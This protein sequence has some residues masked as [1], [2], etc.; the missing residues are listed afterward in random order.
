LRRLELRS[1]TE[2]L[3]KT[4]P[5][6]PKII[7][8]TLNIDSARHLTVKDM[9]LELNTELEEING[10]GPSIASKLKQAG[11]TTIEAVAVVPARELA[12]R[13]GLG[14]ETAEKVGIKAREIINAGFLTAGELLEKRKTMMKCPTGAKEL[15]RLLGGGIETQAITEFA[16]EFGTG[17]TQICLTLSV[18]SQLPPEKGGFGGRVLY[19][20]TE[21]TF[22]PER[23]YQIA[24]SRGFDVKNAME[25]IKI[26]K[27][28]NSDHLC[29]I[30]DSLFKVC[31]EEGVK[32][33][34]VDSIISH[35]RGE[36]LGRE[37]LPERQQKLNLYLHKLIRLA[38][39]YNLAV[40]VTNQVHAKPDAFFSDPTNP[41][42]GHV[43]AHACTQRLLLKRSKGNIRTAA[44]IDSPY[45]PAGQ[46]SFMISE[47]G[48]EDNPSAP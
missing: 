16:G 40:I 21:G 48:I 3:S 7:L 17:K 19:L 15:D 30:I 14:R 22:S 25:N 8:T 5:P 43:L 41:T 37:T 24:E 12:E 20:D 23:I 35:F 38:E 42:G 27:V 18:L 13:A 6:S 47:Q 34:V 32:L 4:G 28:Y 36:Y 33:V 46:I 31:Q 44:L 26:A 9:A 45:L 39:V 11:F 2:K 10:V 1:E 29:I